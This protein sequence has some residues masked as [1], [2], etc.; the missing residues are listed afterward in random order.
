VLSWRIATSFWNV[1]IGMFVVNKQKNK[2]RRQTTEEQGKSDEKK[3]VQSKQ[4]TKNE[5][6]IYNLI[7][8]LRSTFHFVVT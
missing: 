6:R 2:D 1:G 5:L 7:S 3:P 4:T 8:S